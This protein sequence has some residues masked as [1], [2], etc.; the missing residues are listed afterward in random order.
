M[1]RAEYGPSP[2]GL[3]WSEPCFQ[4]HARVARAEAEALTGYS[5]YR[6]INDPMGMQVTLE[7][8][9]HLRHGDA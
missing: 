3:K 9:E 6:W 2:F 7:W 8:L 1:G 5:G 4:D